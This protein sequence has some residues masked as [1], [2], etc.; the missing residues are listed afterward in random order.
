MDGEFRYEIVRDHI[1]QQHDHATNERSARQRL[2]RPAADERPGWTSGI[3]SV[4]GSFTRRTA[5]R[6]FSA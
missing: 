6:P 3:V 5:R 2:T 1:R 4:V